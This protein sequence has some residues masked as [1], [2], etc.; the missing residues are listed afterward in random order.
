MKIIHLT[1]GL[2]LFFTPLF[3]KELHV[4]QNKKNTI[5]FI[6]NAP[7]ENFKGITDKIDG[8]VFWEGTDPLNNSELLFEVDLNT[9]DT[10]IGLRN[11]HMRNNYLETE[12]YPSASYKG[13]LVKV[14]RISETNYT[15]QSKGVMTIHGNGQPLLVNAT[16]TNNGEKF[17]M[18][19][20]FKVKLSDYKIKIPKLMFYK[21]NENMAI[22]LDVY[23]T[24]RK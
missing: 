8:Y 16:I 6:S 9:L 24:E 13:K 18:T 15:V 5:T 19:C 3:S 23:L 1:I 7:L 21:S 2:F 4:D 14:E 20:R 11:R 10:G 12:K 17:Q 22:E